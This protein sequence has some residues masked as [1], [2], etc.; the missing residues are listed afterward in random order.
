MASNLLEILD[1]YVTVAA[2]CPSRRVQTNQQKLKGGF[3]YSKKKEVH[4]YYL[5]K[6]TKLY[7]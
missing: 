6:I 5:M 7:L 1:G 4:Q 2:S 3:F